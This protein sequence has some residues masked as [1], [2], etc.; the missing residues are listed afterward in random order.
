MALFAFAHSGLKLLQLGRRKGTLGVRRGGQQVGKGTACAAMVSGLRCHG[1]NC[2]HPLL[3]VAG[4][5][6]ATEIATAAAT[7]A[8]AG[9][10]ATET[11]AAASQI[12]SASR[13]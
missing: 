3:P 5:T 7:K 11:T 6:A 4:G 10:A 9:I 8:A 1:R 2:A 13:T 12:G